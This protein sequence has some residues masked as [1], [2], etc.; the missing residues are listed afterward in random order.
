MIEGIWL[1]NGPLVNYL[2]PHARPTYSGRHQHLNIIAAL[3]RRD[4]SATRKAIQDDMLEGGTLLVGLLRR[5]D[6]VNSRKRTFERPHRATTGNQVRR[7]HRSRPGGEPS[8]TA[9]GADQSWRPDRKAMHRSRSVGDHCASIHGNG[10]FAKKYG[11][12]SSRQQRPTSTP[13]AI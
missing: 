10:T 1:R 2:Y 5:L 7:Q 8:I 9:A 6:G 3:H 13:A 11:A 12:G 4:A